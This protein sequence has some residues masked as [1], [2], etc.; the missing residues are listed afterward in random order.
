MLKI[1]DNYWKSMDIFY[2]NKFAHFVEWFVCTKSL[3]LQLFYLFFTP[4]VIHNLGIF[5]EIHFQL[6]AKFY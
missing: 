3:N 2:I 4:K 6:F 5:H 1:V